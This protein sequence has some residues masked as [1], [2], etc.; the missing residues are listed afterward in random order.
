MIVWHTDV[1]VEGWG[2]NL[3]IIPERPGLFTLRM[4]PDI[5]EDWGA[6][7]VQNKFTSLTGTECG[8]LS[9]AKKSVE[10]AIKALRAKWNGWHKEAVD[11]DY[12]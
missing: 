9:E 3:A 6:L 4:S 8:T 2:F 10:F 7:L 12:R 5:P 1:V 11:G